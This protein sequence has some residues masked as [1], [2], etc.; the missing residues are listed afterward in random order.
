ML[1]ALGMSL[2][3]GRCWAS[4]GAGATRRQRDTRRQR[5]EGNTR[6]FLAPPLWVEGFILFVSTKETEAD[7][8]PSQGVLNAAPMC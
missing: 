1:L 4:R 2:L 6:L 8:I 3:T 7:A 5:R